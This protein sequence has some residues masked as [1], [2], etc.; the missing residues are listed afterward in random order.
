MVSAVPVVPV[1]SKIP[2]VSIPFSTLCALP[3]ML[4]RVRVSVGVVVV[5]DTAIIINISTIYYLYIVIY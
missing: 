3:S 5:A 1:V 2:V 4:L